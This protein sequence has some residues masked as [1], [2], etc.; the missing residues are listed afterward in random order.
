MNSIVLIISNNEQIMVVSLY[1][2]KWIWLLL[3]GSIVLIF[4]ND[5]YCEN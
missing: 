4:E 5:C 2:H 3:D 1:L